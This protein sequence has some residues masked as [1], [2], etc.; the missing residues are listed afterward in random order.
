MLLFFMSR[1]SI[2]SIYL[3]GLTLFRDASRDFPISIVGFCLYCAKSSLNLLFYTAV[4]E[5]S[6]SLLGCQLLL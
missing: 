4:Y 5:I 2:V 3:Y 6:Y 1:D